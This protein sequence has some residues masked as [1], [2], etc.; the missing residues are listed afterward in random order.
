MAS[1]RSW[2]A[3]CVQLYQREY[4]LPGLA[5]L[6]MQPFEFVFISPELVPAGFEWRR[7]AE[8]V[9]GVFD[10]EGFHHYVLFV[11]VKYT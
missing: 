2:T 11:L 8:P 6:Q 7:G 3:F 10:F 4:F 1:S 9:V 5:Q